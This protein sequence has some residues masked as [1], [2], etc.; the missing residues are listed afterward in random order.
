MDIIYSFFERIAEH[1]RRLMGPVVS[2]ILSVCS[3]ILNY[4]SP[5]GDFFLVI[6]VLFLVN[7]IVGL[8]TDLWVNKESFSIKKIVKTTKEVASIIVILGGSFFIGDKMDSISSTLLFINGVVWYCIYTYSV[9]ILRNAK[10]LLP[11]S[12]FVAF[13]YYVVSFEII[14]QVP[15]AR[16]F[17][18]HESK[19]Q[20]DSN[21]QSQS[22]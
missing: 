12:R 15:Y 22:I 8:L 19:A 18:E 20:R 2:C 4:Y 5:L 7:C 13:V 6:G 1:L 16:R 9:N 21:S 11:D 3:P 17:Q 14:K 10:Q